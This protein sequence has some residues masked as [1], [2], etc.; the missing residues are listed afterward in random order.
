MNPKIIIKTNIKNGKVLRSP[1]FNKKSLK[2]IDGQLINDAQ[3]CYL[4]HDM[5]I[6]EKKILIPYHEVI[7]KQWQLPQ[8]QKDNVCNSCFGYMQSNKNKY[9]IIC[10]NFRK[11][12]YN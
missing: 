5:I 12:F 8:I 10:S 11:C 7:Y 9:E 6:L 4:C 3:Y 1:S 2:L